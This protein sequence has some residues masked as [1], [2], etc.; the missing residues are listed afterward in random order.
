M[1]GLEAV[2][3]TGE[4]IKTGVRSAKGVVGYDLTRLI[5]GSEGTLALIT[6]AT[7][8]LLPLPESV[9]TLTVAFASMNTAARAV[10]QIIRSH[11]FPRT[12]EFMDNASI[13]LAE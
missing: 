11:V 5:V 10:S 8:T 3:P 4:I 7:L 6:E 1:L 12:I 9:M 13:C 2:L